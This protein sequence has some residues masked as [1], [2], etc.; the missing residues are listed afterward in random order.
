MW[1][2][3]ASHQPCW[4]TPE[5]HSVQSHWTWQIFPSQADETDVWDLTWNTSAE[6]AESLVKRLEKSLGGQGIQAA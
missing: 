4:T 1:I 3:P 5:V 6:S 2:F